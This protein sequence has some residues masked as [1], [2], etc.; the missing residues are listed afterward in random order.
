[1]FAMA[2]QVNIAPIARQPSIFKMGMDFPT[3]FRQFVNYCVIT[4]TPA[5]QRFGVMCSILDSAAF[6]TVENLRLANEMRAD[7]KAA[8]EPV[9]AALH[10]P[11]SRILARFAIRHRAQ[12][13]DESLDEFVREPERLARSAFPADDNIRA[14]QTLIDLALTKGISRFCVLTGLFGLFTRLS[15][16]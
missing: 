14:Y 13:E 5:A 3:W 1:M 12:R 9:R 11:D 16:W 7:I 4:N 15:R 8:F 2:D 10:S 6:T